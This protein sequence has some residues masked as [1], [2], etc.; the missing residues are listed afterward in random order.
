[1]LPK[2]NHGAK[3][4][5]E[6]KKIICCSLDLEVE[7]NHACKNFCV[8]FCGDYEDLDNFPQM[9]VPSVQEDK[10]WLR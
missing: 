9:G 4:V 10:R 5:F 3:F 6:T 7:K 8:L 1:M 2:G